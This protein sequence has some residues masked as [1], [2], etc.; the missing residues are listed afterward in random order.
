V[1]TYKNISN[2]SGLEKF[3]ME[4]VSNFVG[5]FDKYGDPR[6]KDWLGMSSP[7][8]TIGVSLTYVFI[9]KVKVKKVFNDNK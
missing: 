8:P 3:M 9:V 2:K 4:L 7:L 6:V 1:L 5:F